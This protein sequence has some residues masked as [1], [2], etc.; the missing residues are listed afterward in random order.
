MPRIVRTVVP[1][2]LAIALAACGS[3]TLAPTDLGALDGAW[4][5]DTNRS[6]GRSQLEC[7]EWGLQLTIQGGRV[8]G[9][10]FDLAAPAGKSGFVSYVETNG[11]MFIDTVANGR[12]VT[13]S[14][15]F[16]RNSFS[17]SYRTPDGCFGPMSLSRARR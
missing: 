9:Q 8:N 14:G 4:E 1:T 5:G 16:S 15:Q 3:S 17:G 12:P 7:K 2:V 6:P 10:I 13:M 11:Q